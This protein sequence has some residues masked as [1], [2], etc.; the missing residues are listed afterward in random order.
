MTGQQLLDPLPIWLLFVLFC[1]VTLL[2]YELAFRFGRWWQA[3][4]PGEQEG[5]TDTL[6]GA[7]LALMAFLLAVTMSMASDRFDARRGLVLEEANAIGTVYLQADY[8]PEPQAARM[9]ALLREYLPLRISSS[10]RA[11]VLAN[12][13][14]SVE[15]HDQMWDIAD[16]VISSG[17][18]PDVMSS[19]GESLTEIVRLNQMRVTAGL[20]ARVPETVIWLLLVGS[21]LSLA[22]V[23]YSAGIRGK[24]SVLSAVVLTVALG[25]VLML[26]LDLDRPQDGVIIV[27]QQP[28]LDV[29]RWVIDTEPPT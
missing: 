21:A 23:G 11:K 16:E 12:V 1:I 28:L 8:L 10:D 24:R 25:I 4:Q 19:F 2:C 9:K 17:Y 5:P 14:R 18:N 3:R 15:L 22:M 7:L 20:Y 6:V 27:S 13:Q 29:Q 26:V